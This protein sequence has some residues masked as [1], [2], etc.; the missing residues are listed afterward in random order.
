MEKTSWT[1]NFKTSKLHSKV[2]CKINHTLEHLCPLPP[3]AAGSTAAAAPGATTS[4]SSEVISSSPTIT[5]PSNNY[6]KLSFIFNVTWVL[7]K[8]IRFYHRYRSGFMNGLEMINCIRSKLHFLDPLYIL[9]VQELVT[10]FMW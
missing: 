3:T 4:S 8:L 9:Y 5:P 1:S 10:H 2:A 7:K 6:D